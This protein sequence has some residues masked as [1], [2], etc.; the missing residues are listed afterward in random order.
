MSERPKAL[1]GMLVGKT[2]N[3]ELTL[4]SIR[5]NHKLEYYNKKEMARIITLLIEN[6]RVK[7]LI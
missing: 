6:G 1:K 7:R 5:K 4:D 2:K 3:D